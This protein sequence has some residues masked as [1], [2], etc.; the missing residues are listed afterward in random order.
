MLNVHR[1][2]AECQFPGAIGCIDCTH[3]AIFPPPKN[4]PIFPE[5]I[6]VNRKGCHSINVQL[7][8][9]VTSI[10]SIEGEIQVNP[11]NNKK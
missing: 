2:W 8:M 6:Y 3:V 9:Y 1:F 7:V 10:K 4:D 11:L 5:N